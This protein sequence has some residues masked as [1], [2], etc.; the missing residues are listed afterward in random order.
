MVGQEVVLPCKNPSYVGSEFDLVV[1]FN[2]HSP[3]H[4]LQHSLQT[5]LADTISAGVSNRSGTQPWSPTI[6][7]NM[8]KIPN[9]SRRTPVTVSGR[10]GRC[11]CAGVAGTYSTTAHLEAS[12]RGSVQVSPPATERKQHQKITMPFRAL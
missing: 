1:T 10:P 6:P 7:P 5:T 11:T 3:Q 9:A 8:T 2:I 12:S 4:Y